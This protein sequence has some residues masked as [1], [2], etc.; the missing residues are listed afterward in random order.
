KSHHTL[1]EQ[2]CGQT[3][4]ADAQRR[5]VCPGR[6]RVLS[7]RAARLGSARMSSAGPGVNPQAAASGRSAVS[8]SYNHRMN[9][10]A[11]SLTL[12]P[13]NLLWLQGQARATGRRSVSD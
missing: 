7:T 13:E 4:A 11:I 6:E 5:R 8:L 12:G 9:K 10:R 1:L 3:T 2:R